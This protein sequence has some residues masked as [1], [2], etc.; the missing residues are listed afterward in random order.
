MKQYF[1]SSEKRSLFSYVASMLSIGIL[2][3]CTLIPGNEPDDRHAVTVEKDHLG[4]SY[5]K[6]QYLDQG[7]NSV[8]S[9]WFYYTTQGSNLMPY[10]FFLA[11]EKPG[12]SQLFR[13]DENM[14]F[15]RYLPQKASSANP[16]ALPVGWVKDK[17]KGKEY[18][19]LTCAACH[20]GQINY[21]GVGIRIDGGPASADMENIMIDLAKALKHTREDAEAK[22]RFVK[23]VLARGNYK[24]EADVLADLSKYEQRIYSYTYINASQTSYGYARLDAF[25]RIYNRVLEH[26]INARELRE[27]LSDRK[28]MDDKVMTK[29]QIDEILAKI[30]NVITGEQRDHLMERLSKYLTFEQIAL[31]NNEIFNRPDAPVSY[32]FLWDI[33]QHDYVQWNGIADNA[34]LGPIGRNTGEVIGVF[35]TL[36]WKEEK[37]TSLTSILFQGSGNTRVKFDSSVDVQN[38]HRIESH[39]KKLNSPVWPQEILGKINEEQAA[40]GKLLFDEYCA[41]CHARID[42]DDPNR[43]VVA[44]MT[45]VS[46]IGT[47][48]TMAEN[49]FKY[50]GYSGILRNQYVGLEVGNI[51]LDKEAPVAALLTQATKNVVATPDPDKWFFQRW[52]DW[53]ANLVTAYAENEIKSSIKNG[54]YDPDTTVNP[55]ASLNAY[56]GR[57]LNGIW[58][59]APYLH[60]GSVPSL[61]DLLL[62]KKREGDPEDGEYRPDQFEVG[63]REFDPVKVGLKSSG[64]KSFTFDTSFPGNSNAGHEYASGKTAQPNGVTLRPLNKDEKLDVL[65]YLKTL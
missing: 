24:S 8:D 31:L 17:Y 44:H 3:A 55:L 16:D 29:E 30:D 50:Q 6:V 51:L 59:T 54:N 21:N 65:E 52:T 45:K 22:Q 9:L 38:L 10:D 4:D 32:P 46:A 49:S 25:G 7:W 41:A 53:A 26:T 13:S 61:Y 34:G 27:I 47:D 1:I 37:G 18:V 35:G 20:T 57:P 23:N 5:T 40:K 11:L 36:D 12:Q 48:S 39:L 43:R 14:N 33:A 60:N 2:S 62:P 56:K 19:G 64:Y 63:S 42:R 28:I 15:Y 58:A